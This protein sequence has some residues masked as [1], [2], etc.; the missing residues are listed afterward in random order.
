MGKDNLTQGRRMAQS[1]EPANEWTIHPS[2][3]R[4]WGVMSHYVQRAR[5]TNKT[6]NTF[7]VS[8]NN[9]SK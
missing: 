1:A 4:C 9:F 5:L 2:S 7:P 3:R 6:D 8:A